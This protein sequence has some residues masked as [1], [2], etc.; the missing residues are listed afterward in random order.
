ALARALSDASAVEDVA[1]FF[2]SAGDAPSAAMLRQYLD[3]R[4]AGVWTPLARAVPLAR[5]LTAA[6]EARERAERGPVEE[7]PP[8]PPPPPKGLLAAVKGFF[9]GR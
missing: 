2:D 8:P 3:D 5:L 6:K 7:A 9:G 1:A 4:A